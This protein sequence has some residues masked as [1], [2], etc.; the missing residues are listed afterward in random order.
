MADFVFEA[1]FLPASLLEKEARPIGL[2]PVAR[3]IPHEVF[4]S[5]LQTGQRYY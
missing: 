1:A 4:V 5:L 2:V 3:S